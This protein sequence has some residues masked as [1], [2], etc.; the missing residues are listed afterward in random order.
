MKYFVSWEKISLKCDFTF[1]T[2]F[3]DKNSDK[4]RT[5]NYGTMKVDKLLIKN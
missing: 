4:V 5:Q 3:D 2:K 1:K